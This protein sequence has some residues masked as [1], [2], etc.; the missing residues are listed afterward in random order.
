MTQGSARPEERLQE[1]LV[2][3]R[4]R[5]P[6]GLQGAFLVQVETDHAAEVFAPGRVVRVEDPRPGLPAELTVQRARPQPRGWLLEVEEI[7][8]RTTA[9]QYGGRWLT[10]PRGELRE[11]EVDEYFLHDLLGLD[12]EDADG[13][14]VGRVEAVY[15]TPAGAL[16]GVV[17]GGKERL[18]PFR[19]EVVEEVD[20]EES[21][22][23]VRAPEGLLEL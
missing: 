19:R 7:G 12:V 14:V 18:V 9:R 22:V 23:R 2:V 6:H 13:G 10:L 20:I 4:I 3:A 15:E 5:R 21:R 16:L 8:D 17:S 11:T 1:R